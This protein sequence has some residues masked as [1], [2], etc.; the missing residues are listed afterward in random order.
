[1]HVNSN[2][3]ED[4][5]KLGRSISYFQGLFYFKYNNGMDQSIVL[6]KPQILITIIFKLGISQVLFS[7]NLKEHRY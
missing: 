6:K 5:F 3:F 2:S 1:M 7:I 4:W